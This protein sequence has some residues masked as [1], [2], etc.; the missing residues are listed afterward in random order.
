MSLFCWPGFMGDTND[1]GTVPFGAADKHGWPACAFGDVIGD[2]G[3]CQL[4]ERPD[5][6]TLTIDATVEAGV[7]PPTVLTLDVEGSELHVL[8]G[9]RHTLEEHRP[10]V[11][12]SIHPEFAAFHY[13]IM[14]VTKA[15][16]WYMEERGY[17]NAG[18]TFLAQD[19][20]HH[21]HFRP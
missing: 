2:H 14:D 15:I 3:F 16:R 5:I 13:G 1:P 20:E 21:W 9:A 8:R 12:V 19:H 7:P 18:A 17:P 11:F 6:P 10:D 4:G